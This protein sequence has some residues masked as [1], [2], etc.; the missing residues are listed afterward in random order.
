M[1]VPYAFSSNPSLHTADVLITTLSDS[2]VM[3]IRCSKHNAMNKVINMVGSLYGVF[4]V[5]YGLMMRGGIATGELHHDHQV[6]FGPALVRAYE[7]ENTRAIY[8]RVLIDNSD[9][10]SALKSC[11]PISYDCNMELFIIDTDDELYLDT[12]QYINSGT[13]SR[14]QTLLAGMDKSNKHICEKIEWLEK[15]I[16]KKLDMRLNETKNSNSIKAL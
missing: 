11:S 8:P 13:L 9:L 4:L 10:P 1:K 15:Y 16:D 2:I 3:S 6:V 7:L 5:E 14:C 12:F